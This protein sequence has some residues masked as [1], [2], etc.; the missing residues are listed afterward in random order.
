M[1]TMRRIAVPGDHLGEGAI[2]LSLLLMT[3]AGALYWRASQRKERAVNACTW[4]RLL[5]ASAPAA[6]DPAAE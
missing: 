2:S 3:G 4:A 1:L 6:G 5:P